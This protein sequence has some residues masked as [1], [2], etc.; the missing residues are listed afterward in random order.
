MTNNRHEGEAMNQK[1]KK[2]I[3]FILETVRRYKSNGG[4]LYKVVNKK[5][6]YYKVR[7]SLADFI[8]TEVGALKEKP[9]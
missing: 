8:E 4:F 9:E 5:K 6:G 3:E 7:C 2:Q 1:E